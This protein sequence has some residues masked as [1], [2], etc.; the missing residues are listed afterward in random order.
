MVIAG[1]LRYGLA[2]WTTPVTN[3]TRFVARG[4]TMLADGAGTWPKRFPQGSGINAG[5]I[6]G[7]ILDSI[8][9]DS[10]PD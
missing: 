1:Q 2:A 4:K 10:H 5:S 8:L 3:A 7:L 9:H 6:W